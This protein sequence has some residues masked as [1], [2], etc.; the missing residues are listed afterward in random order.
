MDPTASGLTID[1]IAQVCHEA[2]RAY[3]AI[4]GDPPG[5]PW[6]LA[7]EHIKESARD[8]VAAVLAKPYMTSEEAHASWSEFKIAA[9]W[10]YGEKKSEAAKTHPNLV[11]YA[12]LPASQRAKDHLFRAIV[13][14]LGIG[15]TEIEGDPDGPAGDE[16]ID[17]TP[18]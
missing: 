8:G 5:D 6:V 11:A 18:A 10:T 9:G 12:D 3:C 4:V 2:N 15:D 17:S 7:S 1:Q 14:A 16:P 13:L